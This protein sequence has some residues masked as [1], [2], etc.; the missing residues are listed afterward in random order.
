MAPFSVEVPEIWP[1][2]PDDLLLPEL[3]EEDPDEAYERWRADRDERE[4]KEEDAA[5]AR[6]ELRKEQMDED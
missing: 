2:D 3:D 1:R 5:I 4:A 6:H